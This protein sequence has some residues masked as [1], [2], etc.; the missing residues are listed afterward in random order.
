MRRP[1]TRSRS[2]STSSTD[3]TLRQALAD[4]LAARRARGRLPHRHR[5]RRHPARHRRA[6]RRRTPRR[7]RATALP[8]RVPVVALPGDDG[9][10]DGLGALGQPA[11]RRLGEPRR[12]DVVQ[13]LRARRGRRLAA[14]HGRRTRARMPPA[15]RGCGSHRARSPAS[16][17]RRRATSRRT[18]RRRSSWHREGR[19]SSCAP[20][21]RRTRPRSSTCPAPPPAQGPAEFEVGS[22]THEWRVRRDAAARAWSAARARGIPRRRHRRPARLPCA[23]RHPQPR[24]TRLAPKPCAPRRC[25]ALVA[26]SAR[27][28]CSPR[29]T[30]SRRSTRPCARRP[31]E[32]GPRRQT[33][34]IAKR[35]LTSD[36]S[37]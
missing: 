21:C 27:R 32:L 11:A 28:S 33:T 37:R 3:P 20:W 36:V 14:P 23:A 12:D 34:F 7:R 8:D 13:P 4:R 19:R 35:H 17:T 25:G 24:S 16:T 30:C 10:D 22:G 5:L 31:P 6:H 1:P 2:S 15:T 9:R 29:R 26:R 18:A